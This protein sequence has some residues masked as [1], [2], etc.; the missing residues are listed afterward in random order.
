MIIVTKLSAGFEEIHVRFHVCSF[1]NVIFQCP[2]YAFK[3]P[4]FGWSGI[5]IR[6]ERMFSVRSFSISFLSM[7][8]SASLC[9]SA[10][11]VVT[12]RNITVR[13]LIVIFM[14]V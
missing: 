8:L 13:S 1:G 10:G 5:S 14:S 7:D 11:N 6:K 3:T 12:D 9:A 4:P 2:E